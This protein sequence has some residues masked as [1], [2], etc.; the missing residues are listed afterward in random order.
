MT[1]NGKGL[2]SVNKKKK[3]RK[4]TG[5]NVPAVLCSSLGTLLLVLLIAAC[6]PLTV[7]RMLGYALYTVVSGSMEPAIPTGSL[8]YVEHVAPEDI[9][10]GDVIAFYDAV[11]V[12]SVI[13]HRVVTNSTVMGEFVTKGDANEANDM[14]PIPYSYLIGR[15]RM[16]VPELGALAQIFTSNA[17]KLAAAS[18]LGLCVVLHLLAALLRKKQEN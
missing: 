17:G 10:E 9:E 18:A 15:V 13:T 12:A 16:S 2:E 7:P 5:R 3:D 8:V 11:D 6:V 14:R 4:K 1:G